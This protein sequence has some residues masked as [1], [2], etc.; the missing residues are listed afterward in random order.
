MGFHPET[1]LIRVRFLATYEEGSAL[2]AGESDGCGGFVRI[3]IGP[4]PRAVKVAVG[5]ESAPEGCNPFVL[6]T[7]KKRGDSA[8]RESGQNDSISVTGILRAHGFNGFHAVI[9]RGT[10]VIV[11]R[12]TPPSGSNVRR[13]SA[14]VGKTEPDC[15]LPTAQSV[16]KA[17]VFRASVA[18]IHETV[19]VT[20]VSGVL[21]EEGPAPFRVPVGGEVK[22]MINAV[23]ISHPD[24]FSGTGLPLLEGRNG[25][26]RRYARDVGHLC[27]DG[28]DLNQQA[29]HEDQCCGAALVYLKEA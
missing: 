10:Y 14:Q 8:A 11:G 9:H 27:T 12:V 13:I 20:S 5:E 28:R 26:I 17:T 15:T 19:S 2:C 21:N 25:E 3:G 18:L 1:G 23:W 24:S 4:A 6:Q 29:N 7:D 16:A 22:H